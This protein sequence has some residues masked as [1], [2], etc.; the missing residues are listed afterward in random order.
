VAL[1]RHGYPA[2]IVDAI[3]DMHLATTAK[4]L[5]GGELSDEIEIYN[6]IRKGCPLAPVLF[7]LAIDLLYKAALADPGLTGVHITDNVR[8][9]LAGY[10]DDTNAYLSHPSEEWR[11]YASWRTLAPLQAC[12]SIEASAW[13]SAAAAQGRLEPTLR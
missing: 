6:G 11:S 7:V 9:V 8:V 5:A 4:F 1:H 10:A 2:P 3:S 12:G 13:P